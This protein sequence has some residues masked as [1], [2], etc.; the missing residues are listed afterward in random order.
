[1]ISTAKSILDKNNMVDSPT[2]LLQN[3]NFDTIG[4]I[5]D[6][7]DF[8]YK[9]NFNSANTGSF[10]IHKGTNED[11]N[12]IWDS[13]I[14]FKV[15]YIPDYNERFEITVS[16][17]YEDKDTKTITYTSLCESELSQI[18]LRNIE[19][20]TEADI[21]NV[22]YDTNFP[23]I[24]YRDVDDYMSYDWSDEKYTNYSTEKKKKV[25][26]ES[27]LLHR[28]LEKAPNYSI[29]HVDESLMK[30]QRTF[31][32]SDTDIY[33]EL[34]GEIAE[35]F[36]CLFI[37][38]SMHR[39]ISAYDLYNTCNKCGYRGDFTDKCPECGSVDFA[40]QYGEDTTV[41]I[42]RENLANQISIESNSDSLKNCFYVE[43]GDDIINAAIR[44][45]NPNG[46]QYI[47]YFSDETKSD[48]PQELVS[49]IEEYNELYHTYLTNKTITITANTSFIAHYNAVVNYVNSLFEDKS[50]KYISQNLVGYPSISKYI[51]EAIDIHQFLKSSMMPTIEIDNMDIDS[52]I[53]NIVTGFKTG[54]KVD[55][56]TGTTY[57]FQNEIA[58]S[59]PSSAIQSIVE[60]R[61][62][63]TA[64]LYYNTALYDLDIE[65]TSY[66][67]ATDASKGE[68]VGKLI[69][70]SIADTDD[71][72]LPLTRESEEITFNISD[73]VLLFTEQEVIVATAEKDKIKDNQITSLSMDLDTFK[74]RIKLYSIDELS[75]ILTMF[76]GCLSIIEDKDLK[77][78]ALYKNSGLYEK[79]RAFYLERI[80]IVNETLSILDTYLGY[81][82]D[83]YWYDST[84]GIS[85]G[86]LDDVKNSILNILDIKNYLGED[87]YNTFCS[88]KREDTYSNSNYIS[89]GLD[90][91]E[92]LEYANKLLE[93]AKKE[94][95]KAGNLQYSISADINNLLVLPEFKPFMNK[96]EVGNWIRIGIGDKVYK[97]R[98]LSYEI[99]LEELQ[100]LTLEFSTVEKIYDGTSDINSVIS[101]VSSLATSYSSIAKQV[102]ND[103]KASNM[104]NNW[105]ADGLL[106]TQTKFSNAQNQKLI[107]DE[108]G[109]LARSYDSIYETYSP[110]QLKIINNGLY[111][112]HDNWRTI[113]AGVGRISYYDPLLEEYVDDYGVIA[114]TLIGHLILGENLVIAN[115]NEE[116]K[117]TVKIDNAG[118]S[119]YSGELSIGDENDTYAK[120][121]KDGVLYAKG[122]KISG[123]IV[124][125]SGYIGALK[126]S[127]NG[128]LQCYETYNDGEEG[129]SD[130][131]WYELNPNGIFFYSDV[132][133]IT[134]FKRMNVNSDGIEYINSNQHVILNEDGLSIYVSVLDSLETVLAITQNGLNLNNSYDITYNS[135]T[136][137]GISSILY[138]SYGISMNFN[139]NTT[140]DNSTYYGLSF[141]MTPLALQIIEN[142]VNKT[143]LFI[144][145]V[146]KDR[147]Y[148]ATKSVEIL[149][150]T[151]FYN[152][153][154][155]KKQIKNVY[156]NSE[157]TATTTSSANVCA[158][159]DGSFC[160]STSSSKRYKHDITTDIIDELNPHKLYDINIY[161]YKFNED[162]ISNSDI[163]YDKDVIGFIAED[164]AEKYPIAAEYVKN[165]D[166]KLI[167]ENWN[168][169]FMIPAMLKLI[170]EQKEDIDKL[171]R[172]LEEMV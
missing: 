38:D 101:S 64:K 74:N 56:D 1:M 37:F 113:D 165:E 163:L 96:F 13:T 23:T 150:K 111:T 77:G 130:P 147:T 155:F 86:V 53:E 5:P 103:S 94:L 19:I 106:A 142:D 126:I 47:Y 7:S 57:L 3:R 20:N 131:K 33:S 159:S 10:N 46:S 40:G 69:L 83:I 97:L 140:S 76:E 172:K 80:D 29:G 41:F 28:L 21:S 45:I 68:Y 109:L 88:Y 160:R 110:Y 12:C 32:I 51:Y 115:C 16:E 123:E 43:G 121:T 82:E 60:K 73:D 52:S 107:I 25:I 72:G 91:S 55:L 162:Y 171:K 93:A 84:D 139:N 129:S 125:T 136:Y 50:Y 27:S 128:F 48:M 151:T 67:K 112:T 133:T 138:D 71:D 30:M 2:L 95:Y 132:E 17:N 105:V 89:D 144:I 6:Y 63:N 102:E 4:I 39:T 98:L 59:S 157:S 152:D 169:R 70:T 61:I 22:G 117:S 164:V 104:L 122:A 108:N 124:A 36:N 116:G 92:I 141:S 9:E 99:S 145:D 100:S 167:V 81:I 62:L 34:T 49:K 119:I 148:I 120:I 158:D 149:N 146:V 134:N 114:K 154:Y 168:H 66:T 90:N 143:Q 156:L 31:S 14:N 44:M 24:F 78:N 75:N 127:E 65:C 54:F 42:D 35:E 15:L 135:V 11:S 26:R 18:S 79:Y 137:G 166:G 153:V 58:I 118:I 87:L 85:C 170:Q 8:T 161:Q